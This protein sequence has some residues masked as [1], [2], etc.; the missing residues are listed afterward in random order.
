MIIN[1]VRY[2]KSLNQIYQEKNCKNKKYTDI[3]K[4]KH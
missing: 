1:L 3:I 4:N 2:L